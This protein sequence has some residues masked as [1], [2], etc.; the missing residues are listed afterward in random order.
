MTDEIKSKRGQNGYVERGQ[1]INLAIGTI[2]EG[3]FLNISK[4]K[5][6][7]Y[8]IENMLIKSG[9]ASKNALNLMTQIQLVTCMGI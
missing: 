2:A 1:E 3:I 7:Q 4:T 9:R 6:P 5:M 8:S